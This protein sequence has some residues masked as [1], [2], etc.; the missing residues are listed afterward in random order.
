MAIFN[1]GIKSFTKDKGGIGGRLVD[2]VVN[3]IEE[4]LE[5]SVENLIGK[6]LKKTGLSSSVS[7]QITSRFG[8][9]FSKGAAD[10]YFKEFNSGLERVTPDQISQNLLQAGDAETYTDAISR[11]T[12]NVTSLDGLPTIQFPSQI[13]KYYMSM[14]FAEYKR[15]SPEVSATLDFK[16]AFVLP[17]PR[18][19]K[20]SFNVNVDEKTQGMAGGIANIVNTAFG[21]GRKIGDVAADQ[22]GA[23]A[24]SAAVQAV[25]EYGEILGQFAG[26]TPNPH[27]QAIFSGIPLRVHKFDWTFSPRNAQES[28]TLREMIMALKAYSLPSYSRLGTAALQYP[29]LCQIQLHPWADQAGNELINFS[30]ALLR[31]VDINYAPQGMPSFFAGPGN[32]PTMVSFSLEFIET[33]IQTGNTY[34]RQGDSNLDRAADKLNEAIKTEYGID[35]KQE[36]R[37]ALSKIG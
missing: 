20:E 10:K 22:I 36:A 24:Y 31:S 2:S 14:S 33:Q 35:A 16:Q 19:L 12:Y 13:G 3:N 11:L 26:A 34:G 29:L 1:L 9:A 32:L 4:Q 27:V 15:L 5:N 21:T 23:L 17:I 7:K 37:N 6:A 25:G 30:P 18:E 28:L 8:D